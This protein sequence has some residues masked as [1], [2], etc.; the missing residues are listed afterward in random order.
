MGS[1]TLIACTDDIIF[2]RGFRHEAEESAKKLIK[3]SCIMR[4][5]TNENETKYFATTRTTATKSNLKIK[6]F[7]FRT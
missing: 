6:G 2:I 7:Y 1:H 4:L 5:V 3:S